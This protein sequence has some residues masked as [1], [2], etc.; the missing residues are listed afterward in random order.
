V[1]AYDDRR[2]P[3]GLP[4]AARTSAATRSRR[5]RLHAAASPPDAGWLRAVV[6]LIVEEPPPQPAIIVQ[7]PTSAVTVLTVR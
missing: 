6:E 3:E 1:R 4:P 2:S 5:I 7:R